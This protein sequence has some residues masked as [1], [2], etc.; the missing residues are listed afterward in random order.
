VSILVN[1][2]YRL[3]NWLLNIVLKLDIKSTCYK[4]TGVKGRSLLYS[5]TQVL[6]DICFDIV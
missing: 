2:G 3:R 4:K 5:L 1:T 6:F